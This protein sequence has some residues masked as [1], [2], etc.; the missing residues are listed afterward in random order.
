M[1]SPKVTRRLLRHF[2]EDGEE[3]GARARQQRAGQARERLRALTAKERDVL[4]ALGRGLSNADIA[5]ALRISEATAKTHIS[6]ILTKVRAANRVQA[7]LLAHHA[8]LLD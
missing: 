7:A 5:A 1:L 8:G 6:R 3:R 4:V 2:A